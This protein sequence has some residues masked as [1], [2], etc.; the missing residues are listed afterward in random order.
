[1]SSSNSNLENIIDVYSPMVYGI[2][3][4]IAPN[5]AIAKAILL[6]TFQKINL[7][8]I[9]PSQSPSFVVTLLLLTLQTAREQIYQEQ[10][11]CTFK[12]QIFDKTPLIRE[13]IGS[14][15]NLTDYCKKIQIDKLIL[16]AVKFR[17]QELV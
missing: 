8:K 6:Q 4:E 2:A 1:M 17:A 14:Q 16:R 9:N 13:L 5:A 12:L 15:I 11:D 10:F 3:L 7:Q